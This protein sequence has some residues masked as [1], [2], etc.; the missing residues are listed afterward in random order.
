M[1]R[2]S[3]SI[4]KRKIQKDFYHLIKRVSSNGVSL[5]IKNVAK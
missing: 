5:L 3:R 1:E 2:T 4:G